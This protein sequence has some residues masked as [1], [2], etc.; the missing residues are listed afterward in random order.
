MNIFCGENWNKK[1]SSLKLFW[2]KN[3]FL[4][5]KLIKNSEYISVL[6]IIDNDVIELIVVIFRDK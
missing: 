4:I 5:V 6:D 3:L 1:W 2:I